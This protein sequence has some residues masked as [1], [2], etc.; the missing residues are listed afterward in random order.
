MESLKKRYTIDRRIEEIET[1]LRKELGNDYTDE[2]LRERMVSEGGALAT[3]ADELEQMARLN[4]ELAGKIVELAKLKGR[5]QETEKAVAEYAKLRALRESRQLQQMVGASRDQQIALVAEAQA[6]IERAKVKAEHYRAERIRQETSVKEL[7]A[8][9]DQYRSVLDERNRLSDL[10]TN[11][12]NRLQQV[13][14]AKEINSGTVEEIERARPPS[15]P[16]WPRPTKFIAISVI[17]SLFAG[18]AFAFWRE[19]GDKSLKHSDEVRSYLQMPILGS[20]PVLRGRLFSNGRL[21]MDGDRADLP[22]AEHFRRLRSRLLHAHLNG[23]GAGVKVIAVASATP[24]EGKTTIAANLASSLAL[25][26][27]R[28]LMIDGDLRRP[29]LHEYFD[30]SNKTGLADVLTGTLTLDEAIVRTSVP[31]LDLL[32]AGETKEPAGELL[33]RGA[34]KALLAQV[35]ARYDVVIIDSCPV[36]GL[37]DALQIG[38]AADGVLFVVEAGGPNREL[39]GAACRELNNMQVGMLGTV[40]NREK[41]PRGGKYYYHYSRYGTYYKNRKRKS[42]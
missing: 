35:A 6:R 40:L 26:D 12:K 8:V 25:V 24:E 16:N 31:G 7:M 30:A 14:I 5:I 19:R 20:V 1:A 22:E 18:L 2:K 15:A 9:M 21:L 27:K 38:A 41:Q 13:E 32:A 39:V 23:N 36:I 37:P 33:E 34:F 28:V 10:L 17:F 29:A 4:Q 42:S 3:Y 11:A